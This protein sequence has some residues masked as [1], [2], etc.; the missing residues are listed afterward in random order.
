M[1]GSQAIVV[2][3]GVVGLAC[4][5]ALAREGW[6]VVVIDAE[7]TYGRGTSSRNSEVVHAG[8]YYEPGSLKAELC[9]EGRDRLYR[10]AAERDV[11]HRRCGKLIV[12]TEPDDLPRLEA[13]A[14]RARVNGVTTL[15][16][17]EPAD[18]TALEPSVR[19]IGALLSP[20]T[21]IIDVHE[22]MHALAADAQRA[23]VDFAFRSR[24]VGA[25]P[26]NGGWEVAIEDAAGEIDRLEVDVVVNCAGLHSDRVAALVLDD[27][28]LEPLRMGWVK[29][30]Y[31]SV[32]AGSAVRASRLIYPAPHPELK[33]LGIHLT[34]DLA[35][36][37]R[38]GPDVEVLAER[39]E[40]YDVDAS[41]AA[42]FAEAARRYLPDLSAEDLSP[43]YSGLRPQLLRSGFRDF[44]IA[45]ESANGAPGWI[46]LVAIESPGLTCAL[47][48]GS[49]VAGLAGSA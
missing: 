48:I 23:G 34:L 32:R 24:L 2:G 3:A 19:S 15:E 26:R 35:G 37:Q 39:S 20:D 27:A 21:G 36:G 4:A 40:G 16:W 18:V 43:G 14:E 46:N 6:G 5:A 47:A 29:G 42:A 22:L 45:E 38:L 33:G 8:I 7:P 30:N 44:Y 1:S 11:P 31:F 28:A 25:E 13:L 9:V 10:Y 17:L 12:A 49:R 41:R